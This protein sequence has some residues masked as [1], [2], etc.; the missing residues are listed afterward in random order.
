MNLLVG[1]IRHIPKRPLIVRGVL[2]DV[3]GTLLPFSGVFCFKLLVAL[4]YGEREFASTG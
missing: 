2:A 4:K 3:V 1:K